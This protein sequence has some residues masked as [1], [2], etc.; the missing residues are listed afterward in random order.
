[1][2]AIGDH[3][4]LTGRSP[5]VGIPADD[6]SGS[7]FVDLVDTWSPR[8]RHL[9]NDI[10]PSVR[11]GVYAQ[12]PGPH[13]ETPAEIRM[14]GVLGAD[15]VGMSTAIEAI[16]ARHLGAEVLGLAVVTNAAAGLGPAPLSTSGMM[17]TAEA[18]TPMLARLVRGVIERLDA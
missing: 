5:L 16:A 1:V 14:F 15:M 3:L 12:V 8:L 2:V 7:P 13:L 9:V 17:G 6:P 11:E 10:D 18:A 4:N